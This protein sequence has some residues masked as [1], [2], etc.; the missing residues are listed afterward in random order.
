MLC[1]H[2]TDLYLSREA[3]VETDQCKCL[4]ADLAV[5]SIKLVHMVSNHCPISY[6]TTIKVVKRTHKCFDQGQ[7]S[8]MHQILMQNH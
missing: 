8:E 1:S 6:K 3:Y 7:N 2:V 5:L 4:L